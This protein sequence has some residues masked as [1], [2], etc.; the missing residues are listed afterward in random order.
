MLSIK[1]IALSIVAAVSI[2]GVTSAIAKSQSVNLVMVAG[3]TNN[4]SRLVFAP[5]SV[6]IDSESKNRVFNYVVMKQSTENS[7]NVGAYTPWCRYGKVQ[8]D[9]RALDIQ[10]AGLTYVYQNVNPAKQ[11][12]WFVDNRYV[13]ANSPAS[14]NL[15]KAICATDTSNN[16]D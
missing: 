8:L 2:V 1:S 6:K 13:V 3:T 4:G 11:P 12:G 15:L 5:S 10:V 14:R 7:I 16:A 9:S